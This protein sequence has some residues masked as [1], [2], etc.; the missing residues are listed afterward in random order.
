MDLRNKTL[1]M[2]QKTPAFFEAPLISPLEP[3][4][5]FL[6]DS[7]SIL[8]GSAPSIDH[9]RLFNLIFRSGE[10]EE[11][12]SKFQKGSICLS[13][14]LFNHENKILL[15]PNGVLPTLLIATIEDADYYNFDSD[16]SDFAWMVKT[17]L[18]W[19]IDASGAISS[20]AS[21][22]LAAAAPIQPP[23]KRTSSIRRALS[24][25]PSR[26]RSSRYSQ[27][28][29]EEAEEW[30]TI[31][32][33]QSFGTS[34]SSDPTTKD[35]ALSKPP[36]VEIMSGATLQA[37]HSPPRTTLSWSPRAKSRSRRDSTAKSS[38]SLAEPAATTPNR[39]SDTKV[40]YQSPQSMGPPSPPSPK[41]S[42]SIH[43]Q[44]MSLAAAISAP[45]V[46][47]PSSMPELFP[48]RTKD[49]QR[50]NALR[51]GFVA[52]I[53]QAQKRLSLVEPLTI[54]YDKVFELPLV[55]VKTVVAIQHVRDV[56]KDQIAAELVQL[57]NFRWRQADG[58]SSSVYS[59]K[60]E[61]WT[62]LT[63][64][65][66]NIKAP[67]LSSGL[68]V[69]LFHTES[70][71]SGL[72]ILVPKHRRNMIP[73]AKIRD[74]AELSDSEWEWIQSTSTERDADMLA[75][76]CSVPK[77]D[78][79]HHLKVEFAR[80]AAKL[81]KQTKVHWSPSDLYTEDTLRLST[82]QTLTGFSP[83]STTN[84][85]QLHP[86]RSES[87][88]RSRPATIERKPSSDMSSLYSVN[89]FDSQS[90]A[91]SKRVVE[92]VQTQNRFIA[93]NTDILWRDSIFQMN[94]S[95]L[96]M[97]QSTNVRIILY[98]KP[99]RLA[100]DRRPPFNEKYLEYH[101]YQ[102][103]DAT[104][105]L[106][107]NP[108][109][110]HSLR[111]VMRQLTDHALAVEAQLASAL[112]AQPDGGSSTALSNLKHAK[113]NSAAVV[114]ETTLADLD[115]KEDILTRDKM[116]KA[117]SISSTIT[118][119]L[120]FF[121]LEDNEKSSNTNSS[122][123]ATSS[124]VSSCHQFSGMSDHGDDEFEARSPRDLQ[125][126]AP[127]LPSARYRMRPAGALLLDAVH[128]LEQNTHPP[129]SGQSHLKGYKAL[130]RIPTFAPDNPHSNREQAYLFLKPASPLLPPE[131]PFVEGYFQGDGEV[132]GNGKSTTSK[133]GESSESV[134]ERARQRRRSSTG[135]IGRGGGRWRRSSVQDVKAARRD[136]NIL[137]F[138]RTMD[139]QCQVMA[140]KLQAGDFMSLPGMPLW[141]QQQQQQPQQQQGQEW[142]LSQKQQ[143]K[144]QEKHQSLHEDDRFSTLILQYSA[145][146]GVGE[147]GNG[148]THT[149]TRSG[150][151]VARPRRRTCSFHSTMT[152]YSSSSF[153]SSSAD[154]PLRPALPLPMSF[155]DLPSAPAHTPVVGSSVGTGK[156]DGSMI[157][158]DE[159]RSSSSS[160]T[161]A[162]SIQSHPTLE[163][164][165]KQKQQLIDRWWNV[166]WTRRMNTYALQEV[167]D[168]LAQSL[169]PQNQHAKNQSQHQQL[170]QSAQ[171]PH[172]QGQPPQSPLHLPL[173][174]PSSSHS[175]SRNCSSSGISLISTATTL[176]NVSKGNTGS[177]GRSLNGKGSSGNLNRTSPRLPPFAVISPPL[178][179][180]VNPTGPEESPSLVPVQAGRLGPEAKEGDS[181]EERKG[182]VVSPTSQV[183]TSQ[184][185]TI[186][187]G[188]S[189]TSTSSFALSIQQQLKQQQPLPDIPPPPSPQVSKTTTTTSTS[190][191]LAQTPPSRPVK[192]VIRPLQQHLQSN[193]PHHDQPH[194]FTLQHQ[195]HDKE[196]EKD[197]HREQP[198]QRR[199]F[200]GD[201]KRRHGTLLATS[202]SISSTSSGSNG[203]NS[204][205]ILGR[206][207]SRNR[208][209]LHLQSPAAMAL[210]FFGFSSS[211]SSS[212]SSS[213]LL[214]LSSASSS[215]SS[216]TPA[217]ALVGRG[218]GISVGEGSAV[219]GARV[220]A[221]STPSS[222][223]P[224]P[225]L[226]FK[227][228]RTSASTTSAASSRNVH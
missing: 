16:S 200:P 167:P 32:D 208:H 79:M 9:Y 40:I 56:D 62:D 92:G 13:I 172:Q 29:Q 195:Q 34:G 139:K 194:D 156:H 227:S 119:R 206:R 146:V 91:P 196:I 164:I 190:V 149:R 100:T 131:H 223:A 26:S 83:L 175:H 108:V 88:L 122:V 123:T 85:D 63:S 225:N 124:T 60:E 22:S 214:S 130:P 48:D 6:R 150:T 72:R 199:Q 1:E 27:H 170:L 37:I 30:Q 129:S 54:L 126:L 46:T 224:S 81:A 189:L 209:S 203:S 141:Q 186:A 89:T 145:T 90:E 177:G 50:E 41:F 58:C 99:T 173:P 213:S 66:E 158:S 226:S 65:Y 52:A 152:N 157:K 112:L 193:Q 211:T 192:V 171:Q 174:S 80:A 47:Q 12:L 45:S 101:P 127:M 107:Y 166:S 204:S 94:E 49:Y 132:L 187:L 163:L 76:R 24:R 133:H 78:P 140:E 36:P 23:K 180:P 176:C 178:P 121:G 219:N 212:S 51:Q 67:A 28:I 18:D 42:R 7:T 135:V 120:S 111:R 136:H 147:N 216:L 71:L 144:E 97:A 162:S 210:S 118:K 161:S 95:Q 115:V 70:H 217:S 86:S 10:D 182:S 102:I 84:H 3:S 15:S 109:I 38:T 33:K 155:G 197:E 138:L 222:R 179:L 59:G 128:P 134:R 205:T 151:T 116:R 53:Q 77:D 96:R 75:K 184:A 220:T 191:R 183:P 142:Q 57:G 17:S 153:N 215:S 55:G 159:P 104:H 25:S 19:N 64:T 5:S 61:F 185:P 39:S 44:H 169:Q 110:Y 69:G 113:S 160:A 114:S 148:A 103:F 137:E 154:L 4:K 105:H 14:V 87:S 165:E 221:I 117:R 8:K 198:P 202:S 11:W 218:D 143:E 181:I 207:P 68:Y 106:V 168:I 82:A 98:V 201:D 93:L 35:P 125:D 2:R 43:D 31:S 74:D 73:L 228:A 188:P 21:S 20:T